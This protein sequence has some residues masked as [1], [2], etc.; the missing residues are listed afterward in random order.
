MPVMDGLQATR[1]IRS[2]EEAG[3]W[4]AAKKAGIELQLSN[5]DSSENEK[6]FRP[7]RKRIP[8]IAVCFESLTSICHPLLLFFF[9]SFFLL[10]FN[11]EREFLSKFKMFNLLRS[12][13]SNHLSNHCA[14]STGYGP[15]QL[16]IEHK[17]KLN[18]P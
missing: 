18:F 17:K 5:S 10:I 9:F 4:D 14:W 15:S 6:E 12:N 1:L 13:Y 3:N 16:Y 8:I 2:F 11:E 7:P